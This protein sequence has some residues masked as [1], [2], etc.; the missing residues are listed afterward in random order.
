MATNARSEGSEYPS[1]EDVQRMQDEEDRDTRD[2]NRR[3]DK[4]R[5]YLRN[6]PS[7]SYAEAEYRTRR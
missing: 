2:W 5:D 4:I 7:D 6:H 3:E 1:R